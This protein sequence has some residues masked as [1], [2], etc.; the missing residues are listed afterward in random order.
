MPLHSVDLYL[1]YGWLARGVGEFALLFL[2]GVFPSTIPANFG[3]RVRDTPIAEGFDCPWAHREGAHR[4]VLALSPSG[5][6]FTTGRTSVRDLW[7]T[8]SSAGQGH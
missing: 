3:R 6:H 1:W 7:G 8:L 2:S 4:L 5:G